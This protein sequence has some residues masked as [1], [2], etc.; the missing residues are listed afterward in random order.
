[1]AQLGAARRAGLLMFRCIAGS[2]GIG[3]VELEVVLPQLYGG[4][5][6]FGGGATLEK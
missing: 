6:R 3:W 4:L 1:M 5:A 2:F